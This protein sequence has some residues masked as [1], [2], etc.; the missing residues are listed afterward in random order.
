ML[1][2]RKEKKQTIKCM[3]HYVGSQASSMYAYQKYNSVL[4][5]VQNKALDHICDM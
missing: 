3:L 4:S 5:Y 1:I 2:S